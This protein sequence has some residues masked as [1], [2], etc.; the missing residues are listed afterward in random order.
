MQSVLFHGDVLPIRK[1]MGADTA[2][3]MCSRRQ[4]L[5]GHRSLTS[6]ERYIEGRAAT[7]SAG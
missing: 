2:Q 3:G 1:P 5:A 6:I 7:H 4:E